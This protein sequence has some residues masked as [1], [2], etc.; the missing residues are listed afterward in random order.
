M[1]NMYKILVQT[2]GEKQQHGR[3]NGRW[4]DD[5]KMNVKYRECG[6]VEWV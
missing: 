3:P 4:E 6:C 2:S 1:K 5:D